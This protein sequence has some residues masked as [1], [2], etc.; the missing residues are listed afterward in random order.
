MSATDRILLLLFAL[1]VAFISAW[2]MVSALGWGQPLEVIEFVLSD[3]QKRVLAAVGSA[4]FLAASLRLAWLLL[5]R[6]ERRRA[7]VRQADLGDVT[8]SLSA[9]ENLVARVATGVPGVREAIP[10]VSVRDERL[11]IHVATWM[12][13]DI[14]IPD[15]ANK[16]QRRLERFVHETVGVEVGSVRVTVRSIGDRRRGW[17]RDV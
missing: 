13:A 7:L 11:Q 14:S 12:T 17:R 3:S 1:A 2:T 5:G 4:A 9:V 15:T 8:I 6:P 10:N 16:L